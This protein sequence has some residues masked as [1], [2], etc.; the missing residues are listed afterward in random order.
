MHQTNFFLCGADALSDKGDIDTCKPLMY[1]SQKA[2]HCYP[3]S[4][5]KP[6]PKINACAKLKKI[7]LTTLP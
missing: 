1:P 7:A 3:S 6:R 5:S 4:S 2:K